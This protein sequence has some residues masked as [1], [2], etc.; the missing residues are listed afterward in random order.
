MKR[1]RGVR[2][3]SR[4]GWKNIGWELVIWERN[5]AMKERLFILESVDMKLKVKLNHK[6]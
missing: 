1:R 6:G 5:V 4:G 3:E 2:K